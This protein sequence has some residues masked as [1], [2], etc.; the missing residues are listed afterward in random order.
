MNM[1]QNLPFG[2]F[3]WDAPAIENDTTHFLRVI[4]R[5]ILRIFLSKNFFFWIDL[6]DRLDS[7]KKNE[8]N[9]I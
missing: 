6:P 1:F 3:D 4:L 9:S 2:S 8:R 7:F 5:H